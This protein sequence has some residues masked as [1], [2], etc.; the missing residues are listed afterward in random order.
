LVRLRATTDEGFVYGPW[1]S[2][3]ALQAT[4]SAGPISRAELYYDDPNTGVRFPGPQA[5]YCVA[6]ETFDVTNGASALHEETCLASGPEQPLEDRPGDAPLCDSVDE[7][8]YEAFLPKYCEANASDCC[9][10]PED[11]SPCSGFRAVCET[12]L[13]SVD[14]DGGSDGGSAGEDSDSDDGGRPDAGFDDA[15]D[16]GDTDARGSEGCTVA[17]HTSPSSPPASTL[18]FA[19]C[20]ALLVLRRQRR[21]GTRQ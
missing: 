7:A 19:A 16:S 13:C 10:A 18:A 1:V 20:A 11:D 5:E 3:E 14:R 6:L 21:F 4:P 17:A 15:G 9:D 2:A 8:E 12:E